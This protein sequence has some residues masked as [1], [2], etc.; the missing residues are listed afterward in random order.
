MANTIQILDK[1]FAC[2][3][4]NMGVIDTEYFISLIKRDDFDYTIWQREYFDKMKPGEFAQ[5]AS[6]YADG[7]PYMGKGQIM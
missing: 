6:A 7:N 1:G 3:V 5:K 2:L 4:E